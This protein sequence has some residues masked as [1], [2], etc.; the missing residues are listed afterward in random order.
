MG[1][2]DQSLRAKTTPRVVLAVA[3]LVLI[4]TA[5]LAALL[6]FGRDA[7]PPVSLKAA[8]ESVERPQ[9]PDAPEGIDGVWTVDSDSGE[10]TFD[11]A[12]GSFAG[13]RVDEVL[14]GIGQFTAVARTGSVSGVMH[15][16]DSSVTSAE[17]Q[18]DLTTLTSNKSG[19][20]G[21]IQRILRTAAN[22]HA[23][24]SL[25]TPL[26]IP[27]RAAVADEVSLVA[28]GDL[29]VN[30]ITKPADVDITARLIGDV[31]VV[32]GSTTVLFSDYDL[33]IPE[34]PIVVS[35]EDHGIMEFQLLFNRDR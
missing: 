21:A 1:L 11:S 23:L 14:A 26:P 7:P 10:F 6:V 34:V 19:R 31:I 28:S 8:A 29:T 2:L 16:A 25:A 33:K 18:V 27:E 12:T 20:D 3:A 13:F 32:V 15:I 17:V 30:G 35:V 5:A 9:A 24:F 22:P 4:A